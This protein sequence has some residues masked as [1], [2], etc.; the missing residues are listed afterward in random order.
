MI[1]LENWAERMSEDM[2]LHDFREKTQK[3]Y[4]LVVRQF[5][6][7][8]EREPEEMTEDDLR[9]YFLYL[10]EEK[11]AAPSSINVAVHG[12]RFFFIHTLQRDWPILDLI[13][14]K[15]PK[16][17]PVVLSEGEVRAVLGVV[18]QPVRRAAL[19]AIYGLGLRLNE[20]LRLEAGDVDAQRM[21]VWVRDGKGARD[22]GVPLPGPLLTRLRR[23]WKEQRPACR[24]FMWC[25]H[26]PRS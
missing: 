13:K 21:M 26:C 8:V 11:K 18:R 12:L 10:R 4:A 2:R 20:G 25:S 16:K 15:Q 6:R 3:S 17:L 9:G 1:T 5:L 7:H 23:F 14:A 19:T 24:T 22:R